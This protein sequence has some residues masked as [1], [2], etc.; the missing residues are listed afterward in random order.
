MKR[1]MIFLVVSLSMFI[2]QVSAREAIFENF[3]F[4]DTEIST[5]L[6]AIALQASRQDRKINIMI[7]PEIQGLVSIDLEGVD[8]ET[9]L[10]VLLKTNNLGF[11]RYKNVITVAPLDKILESEKQEQ[12][13]QSSGVTTLKVF[14]LKYIDAYDAKKAA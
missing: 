7:S 4:K 8:W 14:K 13:R 1:K 12:L 9:A 6:Q 10:N 11:S 5:V 2:G 3:K